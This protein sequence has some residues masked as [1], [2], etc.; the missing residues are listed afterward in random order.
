MNNTQEKETDMPADTRHRHDTV[1]TK[2]GKRQATLPRPSPPGESTSFSWQAHLRRARAFPLIEC[3]ISTNWQQ[4]DWG[5]VKILVARQQPDGNL[6]FGAYLVDTFCLGLKKTFARAGLSRAGY[7]N[8]VRRTLFPRNE[9]LACS[10]ELVHQMI[11]ASIEY[12]ARFGFQPDADFALTQYVLAPRGQLAEPYRLTFGRKGK[13]FF[14]AGPA[15]QAGH[16]LEQL[17][18]TAGAGN[19][20]YALPRAADSSQLGI[21]WSKP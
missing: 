19:Y 4:H 18:Q 12:A 9:R 20:Y 5:L 21:W 7:E 13:P 8:Q 16:I 11:Y 1:P 10:A 2:P 14:V 17:E 6:C 3:W 15:D